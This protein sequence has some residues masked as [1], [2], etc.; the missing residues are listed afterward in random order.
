[1]QTDMLQDRENAV[2]GLRSP[3]PVAPT[4]TL[5]TLIVHN[6][7]NAT[8]GQQL[9]LTGAGCFGSGKSTGSDGGVFRFGGARLAPTE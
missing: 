3:A 8:P 6:D 7:P 1:M 2:K 5:P 4:A 9:A